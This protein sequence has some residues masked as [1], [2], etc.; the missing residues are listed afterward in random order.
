MESIT[1]TRDDFD[2]AIKEA[3]E[4]WRGIGSNSPKA[5]ENPMAMLMMDMQNIAFGAMLM[6]VLFDEKEDK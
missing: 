1:I 3:V 5:T 2:K 4:Q 6:K